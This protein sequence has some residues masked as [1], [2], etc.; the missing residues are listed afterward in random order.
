MTALLNEMQWLAYRRRTFADVPLAERPS[1][2]EF[3]V[4]AI[5]ATNRQKTSD[6]HLFGTTMA[7]DSVHCLVENFHRFFYMEKPPEVHKESLAELRLLWNAAI[8]RLKRYNDNIPSLVSLEIVMR[9]SAL[10]YKGRADAKSE[11]LKITVASPAALYVVRDF[12][13]GTSLPL[14]YGKTTSRAYELFEEDGV[15][16]HMQFA[17]EK[18]IVGFG[19]VAV[20]QFRLN[21]PALST[22]CTWDIAVD[23]SRVIGDTTNRTTIAPFRTVDFD[24]ECCAE[25]GFP[26][27]TRDPVIQVAMQVYENGSAGRRLV[28]DA[29]LYTGKTD[30][31]V[32]ADEDTVVMAEYS[33]EQ[34]LL[35]GV[36]G[37]F[38][39]V[40]YDVSRT[41]N[42][43]KFD[44]SYLVDRANELGVGEKFCDMS[45]LRAVPAYIEV[46]TFESKARGK[47]AFRDVT[48]AGRTEF[49]IC[50]IAR[51]EEKLKS[52]TLNSVSLAFLN[53]TKEDVHHSMIKTLYRG[54]PADRSRL[55]RY[56][57]KDA[58]LCR[59]IDDKRLYLLRYIEQARVCRVPLEVLVRQ[60]QQI[61]T[62][63]Q[64]MKKARDCG[65]IL[66]LKR[67]LTPYVPPEKYEGGLVLEPDVGFHTNPICCFDFASLYPSEDV[68][69]NL[70]YSTLVR[71]EDVAAMNPD[72]V[73]VSPAGH[74]FVRRH[75]RPGILCMILTE[76]LEAR[77]RAKLDMKAAQKEAEA[78]RERG[79]Y[80]LAAAKKYEADVQEARQLALKLSA[81]ASYGF[82]GVKLSQGGRMPC[83]EISEAITSYGRRDLGSV[84]A[85]FA[86]NHPDAKLRYGDTDSVMIEPP[87]CKSVDEARAWMKKV[88]PVINAELFA[89]RPPMKLAPEKVMCPTEYQSAKK[90]IFGKYEDGKETY[91]EFKGVEVQRR[92]QCEI[93]TNCLRRCCDL[94]FL[95]MNV[96]EAVQHAR[97]T[98]EN[99]YLNR[100]NLSELIVSKS[101]SQEVS[102]YSTPQPHTVVAAKMAARDAST[103][104]VVGDRVAYVMIG[105]GTKG[106]SISSLAEDPL[107]VLEHEIPINVTYYIENQLAEPLKRLFLPIIGERRTQELFNGA[108]TRKR[109]RPPMSSKPPARG[110]M[111]SFAIVRRSCD[112][113]GAVYDPQQHS[114]A[115]LCVECVGKI[116]AHV[117]VEKRAR[118]AEIQTA[119]AAQFAKCQACQGSDRDP[120]LCEARDC[121]ELYKRRGLER[122]CRRAARDIEDICSVKSQRSDDDAT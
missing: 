120:V 47:Q 24:I 32:T 36:R 68:A 7:G 79:E 122:A 41:F 14:P 82:T 31:F 84:I 92:D 57:H 88:A 33:S 67:Q 107:Y 109:V 80:E 111:M 59:L 34:E 97:D 30:A 72:D 60:G 53:Q 110:S 87:G 11:Y 71:P 116:S 117:V 55:A 42:G 89:H 38:V 102:E 51:T 28:L 63:A 12:F 113:C 119:Y 6:V 2:L 5:H 96:P 70:D 61:K 99:L 104:P 17:C 26:Q 58:A 29:M 45:R 106:G 100:V 48:I 19:W 21:R 1:T 25:K 83:F 105:D 52:Y 121:S 93:V 4:T 44:W 46:G 3:M 101:L 108:H 90:Y 20:S 91:V 56:C 54:S 13:R 10:Y 23:E 22:T 94:I 98:I 77:A 74:A 15:D 9:E 18:N 8:D 103:A 112:E 49:D 115:S 65:F 16:F 37:L 76:L 114:H 86:A 85:W 50:N 43:R 78:L 27:A 39:A 66:P 95:H 81:N 73:A 40:D 75:V 62:Q 69:E 118:L 64:L 35:L